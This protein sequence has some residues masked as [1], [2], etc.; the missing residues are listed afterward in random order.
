[1]NIPPF[2]V[3]F[4]LL[5]LFWQHRKQCQ[6]FREMSVHGTESDLPRLNNRLPKCSTTELSDYYVHSLIQH[7]FTSSSADSKDEK[8]TNSAYEALSSGMRT[9]AS[10]AVNKVKTD[11]WHHRDTWQ[12]LTGVQKT[13]NGCLQEKNQGRLP[14]IVLI[15]ADL[16][17][18]SYIRIGTLRTHQGN[19]TWLPC[20]IYNN[21]SAGASLAST[22]ATSH[23]RLLGPRMEL[24][25]IQMWVW[26]WIRGKM[27][28]WFWRL[29]TK[30]GL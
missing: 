16:C 21:T 18:E 7:T 1:M 26:M 3:S 12:V 9:F 29:A 11:K 28:N 13:H 30:K 10:T 15:G 23:V 17:S 24:G 2:I 25:W 19:G 22:V 20:Q 27:H 6:V 14:E 5:G 8:D 4:S